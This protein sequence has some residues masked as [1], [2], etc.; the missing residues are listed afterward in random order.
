MGSVALFAT[1]LRNNNRRLRLTLLS[2]SVDDVCGW[3]EAVTA[4]GEVIHGRLDSPRF[5][6][7]AIRQARRHRGL[8]VATPSE[9]PLFYR[10]VRLLASATVH[11]R[12]HLDLAV[13]PVVIGAKIRSF[14]KS[15]T[16]AAAFLALGSAIFAVSLSQGRGAMTEFERL[17]RQVLGGGVPKRAPPNWRL[18]HLFAPQ[19]VE[20]FNRNLLDN[21]IKRADLHLDE[22]YKIALK[23]GSMKTFLQANDS[24]A[25]SSEF[26]YRELPPQLLAG[27]VGRRMEERL[28]KLEEEKHRRFRSGLLARVSALAVAEADSTMKN[29]LQN[30]RDLQGAKADNW[31]ERLKKSVTSWRQLESLPPPL[32]YETLQ[33]RLG[34]GGRAAVVSAFAAPLNLDKRGWSVAAVKRGEELL[35]SPFIK[36]GE[37]S[38]RRGYLLLPNVEWRE[39]RLGEIIEGLRRGPPGTSLLPANVEAFA[40]VD[41]AVRALSEAWR[42]LPWRHQNPS[43]SSSPRLLAEIVGELKT[44][45]DKQAAGTEAFVWFAKEWARSRLAVIKKP[46]LRHPY[47][48]LLSELGSPSEE[49]PSG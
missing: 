29:A 32:W 15:L 4:E 34:E 43:W 22:Q 44:E 11:P 6:L 7:L 23:A 2:P 10:F 42:P 40:A 18:F 24:L 19:R 13:R 31:R 36:P 12:G 41:E 14:L 21:L 46:S 5:W 49:A 38:F 30:W 27:G 9:Q 20:V 28:Q 1:S 35:A 17:H 45:K 33:D 48:E 39:A 26:K 16:L 3:V 8:A 37:D 47:L 25:L